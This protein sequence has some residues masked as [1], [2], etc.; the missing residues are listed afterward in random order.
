M[1]YIIVH[2]LYFRQE[3]PYGLENCNEKTL[4]RD[5]MYTQTYYLQ[6]NLNTFRIKLWY[7]MML[8]QHDIYWW[9]NMYWE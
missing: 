7:S 1:S 9:W 4:K 8:P 5:H 2:S 6:K 3:P